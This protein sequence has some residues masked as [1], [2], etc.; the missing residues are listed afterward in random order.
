MNL[1]V[2][3][4]VGGAVAVTAASV[5]MVL[6]VAYTTPP[7]DTKSDVREIVRNAINPRTMFDGWKY[8]A[9]FL[10]MGGGGTGQY[11][12][13]ITGP[14]AV[15]A[16]IAAAN[17]AL[18]VN[19]YGLI[20]ADGARGA[21]ILYSPAGVYVMLSMLHEMAAGGQTAA[22]IRGAVGS[23]MTDVKARAH[24]MTTINRYGPH[25][26]F[27]A[28]HALWLAHGLDFAPWPAN[29]LGAY[30][31]AD[32]GITDF[33]AVDAD[34]QRPGAKRINQWAS[35]ATR[36][37]IDGMVSDGDV[38]NGTLLAA[39][40][41]A[42]LE[43]AWAEG[44]LA[45]DTKKSMFVGYGGATDAD[46]MNARGTFGYH[47]ADG[48]Q[49][50]GMPYADGRLSMLVVLPRDRGGLER[51]E[52]GLHPGKITG[53]IGGLEDE[54][55]DVSIPKF[56]L[57]AAYDMA[58]PLS[59]LNVTHVFD[60]DLADLDGLTA[61]G[62]G[63]GG[64]TERNLHVGL[65][66][67]AAYMRVDEMGAFGAASDDSPL[68][69][70]VRGTWTAE[71]VV[72]NA[73]GGATDRVGQHAQMKDGGRTA[74]G[75]APGSAPG[76]APAGEGRHA[77]PSFVADRPFLFAVYDEASGMILLMGRISDFV[78]AGGLAGG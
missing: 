56:E 60:E 45:W 51:V 3:L 21:N 76:S 63:G 40:G 55:V 17:N 2:P 29:D 53:W 31:Y 25:V 67:H 75:A 74:G 20:S 9:D 78:P 42:Y 6:S 24:T 5:L 57:R 34:G 8:P 68:R 13:V 28:R 65:A 50:L 52:T 54:E 58:R 71:E 73:V 46:F 44:F 47:E 15:P 22:Q 64:D 19:L 59:G 69:T 35:D 12:G 23:E 7:S 14:S 4:A 33:A 18:A 30:Y 66:A 49:I 37:M 41:T 72:V 32:L 62:V 77:P 26:A 48:A 39:T 61:G 16:G 10:H 38:G 1:Y 36:G 70:W 27:D 11:F 43:G